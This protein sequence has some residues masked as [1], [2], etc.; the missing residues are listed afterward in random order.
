MPHT[1]IAAIARLLF[2]ACLGLALLP[3]PARAAEGFEA[4]TNFITVLPA[5]ISTPGTW[6]LTQDLSMSEDVSGPGV[7]ID[8]D[9]VTLDCNGFRIDSL[10]Y[11]TYGIRAVNRRHVTI[12]RCRID[13]FAWNIF[14][15]QSGVGFSEGHLVEDN[16]VT[17][18]ARGAIRLAG[19]QSVIQRNRVL[20]SNATD[21]F[22]S[23]NL[24]ISTVGNVDVVDNLINGVYNQGVFDGATIAIFS[25]AN[26]T[27]S[28]RGN[29][30]QN[31]ERISPTGIGIGIRLYNPGRVIVRDN[32]L[33]GTKVDSF[34]AEYYGIRCDTTTG[35]PV[36]TTRVKD[37]R[38]FGFATAIVGCSND[39]NTIRP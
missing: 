26:L 7:Q 24:A 23:G 1:A 8:A 39:G 14:L 29:R 12:R 32:V 9:D 22:A 25:D 10:N 31:V 38:I 27:G 33:V 2:A 30:I 28:I 4:C 19:H 37:N 17:R 11:H 6:C 18:A 20:N 36:P 5:V 34:Y 15:E 35:E 13:G 21:K 16:L 3:A